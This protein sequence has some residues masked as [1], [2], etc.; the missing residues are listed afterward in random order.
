MLRE[1]ISD[2]VYSD[3]NSYVGTGATLNILTSFSPELVIITTDSGVIPVLWQKNMPLTHSK[4]FDGVVL[5]N[6]ILGLAPEK[7]GFQLGTNAL[8]NS[9]SIIYRWTAIGK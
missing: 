5:T 9:S 1:I 3:T 8:V 4:Q 7:N 6:A 2:V